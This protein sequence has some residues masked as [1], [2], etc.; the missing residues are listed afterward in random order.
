[1]EFC[2]VCFLAGHSLEAF[3]QWKKLV[4][5]FC[6]CDLAVR[7]YRKLYDIF[8]SLLEI[9]VK[10]IP[11]EFLA[12]IVSNNNFVYVNLR[13][14][15]RT[16]QSLDIDGQFNSKV[17][18]FKNHLTDLYEW[19]FDHLESEDEDEAPVIVETCS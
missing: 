10:E 3:E 1:M 7:K 15:F 13:R 9:Q 4:T 16:V 12:D 19:D 14:L 17:N 6:S 11:E 2:F 18:R 8:I 5:L